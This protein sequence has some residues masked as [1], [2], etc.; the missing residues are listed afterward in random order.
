MVFSRF[1]RLLIRT[2]LSTAVLLASA[3]AEKP[4]VL[5]I[6]ADDLGWRDLSIEGSE[7]YESPNIDRIAKS[8]M[9]FTRGYA[10]CQ[11]CSPSRAAIMTG[12]APARLK[13]TDWIG[14][15]EEEGW[16]RNTKLLPPKYVHNLPHD[17][18]SLAEAFKEAGYRTF[19]AGKW[20]LGGE[21]SFPDDHGFEINIG[22]HHRGSPPGGFFAPYKNPKMEDGPPGESLPVRL[23]QETAKFIDEH[24][25]EPF[26][27]YLAFYQVHAPIQTTPELW[28]KYQK[29]AQ[30][31]PKVESRFIIDRTSP[32][33]Q[34]QD[35]PVY[36][37]MIEAMDDGVGLA[38]EA[39]DRNGLTDN[40]IIVFTSDNGGC[41]RGRRKS[42]LKL[43]VARR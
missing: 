15:G 29:K 30:Q 11:V 8:G 13:I 43:A 19:F 31:L 24:K 21:G 4:N 38:L 6:L 35:H 7:F 32:V 36:A 40:T 27:A 2:L 41:L 5:F 18:V 39:L 14:A 33:R 3:A 17:D 10:A 34:V 16:K 20:H 9:R 22:G 26:L 42:D 37:G 25:D 12:K 1:M 23:G 28:A